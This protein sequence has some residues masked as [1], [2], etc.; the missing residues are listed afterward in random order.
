MS[1]TTESKPWPWSP[2][3]PD[4][5]MVYAL[6]IADV[7]IPE[8]RVTSVFTPDQ[9]EEFLN[10]LRVEGQKVPAEMLFVQDKIWLAD[11][12]NRILGLQD[13]GIAI[14][15]AHVKV[16]TAADVQI[17]NIT[18][19]RNRGRE[20]PA[21]TALVIRDLID[22]EGAQPD[23]IRAR[24]GMSKSWFNRLYKV[25]KLPPEVLDLV[26]YG[27]LSIAVAYQ[28]TILPTAAAQIELS[29]QAA[30]WHYTEQQAHDAVVVAMSPDTTPA[31]T[32]FN[33][34]PGGQPEIKF[35]QCVICNVELKEDARYVWIC[36][37]DLQNLHQA[38]RNDDTQPGDQ[39]SERAQLSKSEDPPG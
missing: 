31:D 16:G 19:A 26:K 18:T 1:D 30:N 24:L 39:P 2:G 8:P 38:L 29:N 37:T 34:G 6:N 13:I 17:A 27:H 23:T 33:F 32:K 36:P 3:E 7:N 25:A 9:K 10:S 35:P 22:N 12:L 14:I 21:Q 5:N 15:K 28:L 11:G 4:P 20:N